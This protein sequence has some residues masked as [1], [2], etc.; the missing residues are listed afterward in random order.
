MLSKEENLAHIKKF[1][2]SHFQMVVAT[3]D[4]FPWI[5]TV[6]Y[7]IDSD[8]NIYFLTGPSTI[9]GKQI[10]KNPKVAVAIADAPQTPTS[11]K[12]GLQIYGVCKQISGARKV[13]HAITLWKQTLGVTSKDYSYEGMIKKAITGRMYKITP[14]KIKF[15]NEELWEEGDECLIEL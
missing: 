1:L 9:H 10:A 2:E 7:S 15:Y 14:K 13:T 8:L 5:C 6:Y 11:K 12:K 3:N 4:R